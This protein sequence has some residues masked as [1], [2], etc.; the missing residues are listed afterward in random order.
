MFI[1]KIIFVVLLC[2]P[3]FI[4]AIL[5]LTKLVEDA[6]KNMEKSASAKKGNNKRRR[7]RR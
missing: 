6:N 7:Q 4:L 1:L 5:L 2:I 3:V